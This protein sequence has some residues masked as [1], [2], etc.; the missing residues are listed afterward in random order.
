MSLATHLC[1]L[2]KGVLVGCPF[3]VMEESFEVSW[4]RIR[5]LG[6]PLLWLF[7]IQ[8]CITHFLSI[9]WYCEN[10]VN[11]LIFT[12]R[13]FW[14]HRTASEME[15][16][17]WNGNK[18]RKCVWS[19]YCSVLYGLLKASCSDSISAPPL[20]RRSAPP[21]VRCS[22][23]SPQKGWPIRQMAEWRNSP[24]LNGH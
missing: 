4:Y 21:L 13:V 19:A 20:V 7:L 5:I 2:G 8:Y 6:H 18:Y 16:D 3:S 1:W 15:W 9:K 11:W 12:L 14:S 22:C 10:T 17:V 24:S 23:P